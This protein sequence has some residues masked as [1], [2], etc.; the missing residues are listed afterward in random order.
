M[1][2]PEKTCVTLDA[3]YSVFDQRHGCTL[4]VK[5][6]SVVPICLCYELFYIAFLYP[7][8]QALQALCTNR[9]TNKQN[10]TGGCSSHLIGA[11]EEGGW[12]ER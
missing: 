7:S 10:G 4:Y 11:V 6:D 9:E 2:R 12:G 8:P 1:R 3:N 5:S